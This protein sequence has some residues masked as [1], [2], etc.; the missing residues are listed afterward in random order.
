MIIKVEQPN[1]VDCV[2]VG[3]RHE[4]DGDIEILGLE[5]PIQYFRI[6]G[7]SYEDTLNDRCNEF[8]DT[9]DRYGKKY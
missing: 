1:I 9:T 6:R 2:H 4:E 3:F 8:F 7:G 5:E